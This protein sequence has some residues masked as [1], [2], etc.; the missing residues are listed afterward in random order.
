MLKTGAI[1]DY[2]DIRD[3]EYDH[4][5]GASLVD[6]KKGFDIEEKIGQIPTKNQ[7]QSLSCVGQAISYYAYVLNALEAKNKPNLTFQRYPEFVPEFSAKSIY[8]QIRVPYGGAYIRDGVKCLVNYGINKESEVVSNFK[9]YTD[10]NWMQDISWQSPEAK[11]FASNYQGKEYRNIKATKNI[12]L[13]AKA[14]EDY[15]GLVFGTYVEDND[16][17]LSIYP[18]TENPN[19]LGHALYVGKFCIVLGKKYIG[20]KN[21][22][23]EIGDQ[24]WQWLNEDF[25]E[26]GLIFSPWVVLDKPNNWYITLIDKNGKPRKIS[27]Y[28]KKMIDYLINERG[29][30]ISK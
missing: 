4:I 22:W 13:F 5:A 15:G 14:I 16:T 24:G 27:I 17:W 8:S 30:E 9:G 19:N 29:Y 7:G 3:K 21:S 12:D 2:K 1:I 11:L 20:C 26:K 25:F 28:M 10:E 23:G 18:K 6:W